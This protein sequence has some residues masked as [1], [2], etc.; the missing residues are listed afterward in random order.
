MISILHKGEKMSIIPE[1]IKSGLAR[2]A[3]AS[4][5]SVGDL[6]KELKEIMKTNETIKQMPDSQEEFKIRYAW[7]LLCKRHS[8]QLY[9]NTYSNYHTEDETQ[10][11]IRT[12]LIEPPGNIATQINGWLDSLDIELIDIKYTGKGCETS[13]LM[14]FKIA[15]EDVDLIP[16]K[17]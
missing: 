15:Y 16:D 6:T 7:A 1:D 11:V 4:Y 8:K 13:A 17:L 12:I 14:I 5:S 2:L 10:M 3:K 9:E